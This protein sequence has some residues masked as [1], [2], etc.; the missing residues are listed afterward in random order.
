MVFS[1]QKVQLHERN[2]LKHKPSSSALTPFP[3]LAYEVTIK[4]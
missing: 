1:K 2:E 4:H 3:H